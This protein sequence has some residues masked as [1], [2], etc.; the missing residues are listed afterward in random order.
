M[1]SKERANCKRVIHEN[2]I[3]NERVLDNAKNNE[4]SI[5]RINTPNI[6]LKL[7]NTIPLG[8]ICY[9]SYGARFNSDKADSMK[10]TKSDLI[11]T[12]KDKVHTR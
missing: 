6:N 7:E 5:F 12:V 2:E 4:Y 11:S 1:V 10:F 3:T 8:N 9:V